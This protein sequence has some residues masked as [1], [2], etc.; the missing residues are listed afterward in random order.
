LWHTPSSFNVCQVH[1]EAC[2][3]GHLV[4]ER[5]IRE[6][7]KRDI[8]YNYRKPET[9]GG[10]MLDR[11]SLAS[12]LTAAA[13]AAILGGCGFGSVVTGETRNESVS[14]DL[15]EA[16]SAR[17]D[18]RMGSGELQ[19]N[20]GTPK[21]VEG[22]FAYNVADWKPVVD[23]RAGTT[24]E[25]KI[26]QPNSSGSFGN[27]V[28]RWDV[29]LNGELPLDITA[30]LGAGEANLELGTMTLSRVEMN[31]GAGK[32]TMD[33]RGEPKHDYTVQIRGG[34]GETVVYL[35]KDVGIAA[36]ATKGIGDISTERLENRDG[37]WVNPARIGAP[38][39][40]RLDVK[41]GV[42]AIRLVR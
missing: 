3:D 30:T 31:I 19:V 1:E 32:V 26:S 12:V 24:G 37:V 16:T 38:V 40:V 42:G 36:S 25:L 8:A 28:N 6:T 27:T 2:H 13:I 33:L 10:R 39:T 34:V 35:P 15:G 29:K 7:P 20:S 4:L 21:L 41:G 18:L 5:L 9:E 14:F 22:K 23:Y 11:R 17:V